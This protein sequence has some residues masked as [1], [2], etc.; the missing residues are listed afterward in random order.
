M[1]EIKKLTKKYD[2]SLILD[3]TSLNFPSEG[4]VCLLGPSGSGKSTLLN[5]VAGF[6][7]DY[8]GDITVCGTSISNM[9]ADELCNYR[10]D[11]IGFIFQNYHLLSGYT[12][13]ENILLSCA[14]NTS[15]E[16]ENRENAKEL[17]DKLGLSQKIDE[18]IE[19]LSGGQK[20]RVAI[21]RAIISNPH[22]ILAD[23]P[24]GAL[25][26]N[27]SNEI[28]ALL[29]EISKDRLV[30]VITHDQKICS[31]ADE[32]VHIENGKLITSNIDTRTD[33]TSNHTLSLKKAVKVSA[34]KRGLKNF[35]VHITRYIAIS[36]AISI[37]ILAFMLSLSSGNSIDK[38]ISDFQD[39]NTAYNNG[40][41][42]GED[43]D[44]TVFDILNADERIGNVYYQYKIKD[45]SLRLG[46]KTEA[47]LEKYPMAKATEHMSYGAMPKTGENEIALSPSLAKKFENDISNMLGKELTLNYGDKEYTLTISGIYNAGY[48]DFFVSSD[49]EQA[50]YEN[51]EGEKRYSIN[52]DVKDFEDIV[53]VSQMLADKKIDSKNSAKEVETLQSTF[54]NLSRLFS[55]VSILILAI[56]LFI[57]TVL[58]IKLQ[59]SRYREI[60]LL[61]ALGYNKA[62][63]R[64][65]I[66]SENVLLAVMSVIFQAA[67]IGCTHLVGMVFNLAIIITPVQ[68]L[69]SILSTGVVV[70]V[71]SIIASYNLI[72]T[73]PA[74]ALRK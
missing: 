14:L 49:I 15:S 63:V 70:I 12:V 24:T 71:I 56:G 57:S 32:V 2:D 54:N 30:I 4:L 39:N 34:F 62:T 59:N 44:G 31:L 40:Y 37:G 38:A 67:L 27:N 11:N 46:D 72:R 8:S 25:D 47:L 42:K 6:D 66:V 13:F 18:K 53:S 50:F 10:R 74:V 68:I 73:E 19:N 28:M 7:S 17:L 58:L 23:E 26:R 43:D 48:D 16:A 33:I 20:Q 69:L 21:A 29:K 3:D 51:V 41:I 60:G 45:V 35:K 55:I 22:I 36:L 64:K 61:S 5:M 9:N 1:I 52:Y 65:I